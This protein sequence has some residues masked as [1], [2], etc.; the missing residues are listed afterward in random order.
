[1]RTVITLL[2][3]DATPDPQNE[4]MSWINPTNHRPRKSTST[5][6]TQIYS[7]IYRL[8]DIL[9]RSCKNAYRPLLDLPLLHGIDARKKQRERDLDR[10]RIIHNCAEINR[11]CN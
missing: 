3:E 9:V 1:M 10:R 8:F 7:N 6:Q 11:V 4:D 2:N 5:V